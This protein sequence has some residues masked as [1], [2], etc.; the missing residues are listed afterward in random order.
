MK[1]PAKIRRGKP[2]Q[3]NSQ[4]EA[5][6]AK[7]LRDMTSRMTASVRKELMELLS[8]SGATSNLADVSGIS[9][10]AR[11]L[12][13]K[14][15]ANWQ[16]EF[17]KMS[18]VLTPKMMK[19][20]FKESKAATASSLKY[21]YESKQVDLKD[22]TTDV[23]N[24][25]NASVDQSVE[26]FKTI[27]SKYFSDIRQSVMRTIVGGGTLAD[28]KKEFDRYDRFTKHRSINLALDQSRKAYHGFNR[29][30]ILQTGTTKAIWVHTG[31]TTHPRKKH[32]D[33]NGKVFNLEKGAP[34]GTMKNGPKFVQPADESFC[35]CTLV[36]ILD[37]TS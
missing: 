33:F 18:K 11:I 25:F 19:E 5:R 30:L 17:S 23:K 14:M 1:K 13:N 28:L 15:D 10:K 4:L 32:K 36:P 6:Y 35:R 29:S 9:S 12:L 37:F 3:F 27:P 31:G 16:K 24:V 34:V 7:K 21:L 22:A 20:I 26:L 2:I 8:S